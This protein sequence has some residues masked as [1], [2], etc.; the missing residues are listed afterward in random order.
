MNE[1]VIKF[2]C[3]LNVYVVQLGS[4]SCK[5]YLL[6]ENSGSLE[7]RYV[8][9]EVGLCSSVSCDNLILLF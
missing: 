1:C 9:L 8:G 3:K 5:S 4:E 6:K 2:E 7:F